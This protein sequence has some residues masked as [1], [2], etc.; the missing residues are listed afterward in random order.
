MTSKKRVCG[1]E[2]KRYQEP[3]LRVY[4]DIRTLT[5]TVHM[6]VKVDHMGGLPRKTN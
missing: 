3:K 4:G 6:G 2:K 1:R 5:L